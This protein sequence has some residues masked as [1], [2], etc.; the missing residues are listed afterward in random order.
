MADLMQTP[1]TP[2]HRELGAKLVHFAGYE[3]PVQFPLG[4]MKEHLHCRTGAGLFDVSHMGQVDRPSRR[5]GGRGP[6][7]G[8]AGAAEYPRADAGAAA[9]RPAHRRTTA[10]S[11]T[12]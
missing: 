5:P 2:L 12:T 1:L 9:L 3:M 4:V 8:G 10:A 7:A 11:S 6:G